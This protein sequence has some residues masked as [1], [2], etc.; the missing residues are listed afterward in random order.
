MQDDIF[1]ARPYIVL[2]YAAWT[3]GGAAWTGFVLCPNGSFS[4]MSVQTMLQLRR[5]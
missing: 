2:S 4:Q 3:Q 5:T 1:N